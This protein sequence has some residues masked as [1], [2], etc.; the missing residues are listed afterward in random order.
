MLRLVQAEDYGRRRA[1]WGGDVEEVPSTL[2]RLKLS[3]V[4][5]WAPG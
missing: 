4:I 3:E 5:Y 2:M 1:G